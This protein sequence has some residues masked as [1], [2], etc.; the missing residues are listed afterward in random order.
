MPES[1]GESMRINP[2]RSPFVFNSQKILFSIAL[3]LAL[4]ISSVKAQSSEPFPSK[5]IRLI[6]GFA[7]G[8]GSDFIAR[9]AAQKLTQ[10]LGQPV[11]VENRPGAGGNLAAEYALKSDNDGYTLLLISN[12]YAVNANIYKLPFNPIKDITPIAKLA[13]GPFIVAANPRIGVNNLNDFVELA[14]KN[15]GTLTYA[16]AGNGSVTHMATEYFVNTANIQVLH[17]PYK[18]TSPALTDTMSGQVQIMFG[19]VASTAPHVKS[20]KL[21]ALAVTTPE[22]LTAFPDTPTIK[23]SG[24]PDYEVTVWHGVIG[25]KGIPESI[26]IKL[27]RAINDAFRDPALDKQLLAE[28]L[29]PISETP[30]QFGELISNEIQQWNALVKSKKMTIH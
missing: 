24:F 21:L 7:P 28:G 3:F 19:S 2:F 9:I 30:Q 18:G 29:K 20:G 6:V 13:E 12:S 16:S 22:R 4:C 1:S 17:I 5:P 27:N 8:G 10:K 15:P 11:I 23:E 26:A 25:P 14:K